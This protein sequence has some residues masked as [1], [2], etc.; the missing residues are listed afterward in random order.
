M[1]SLLVLK[2]TV[3]ELVFWNKTF[4]ISHYVFLKLNF[5]LDKFWKNL[6]KSDW[7]G[8]FLSRIRFI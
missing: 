5:K 2:V 7:N 4:L 1:A 6:W 3:K 8:L